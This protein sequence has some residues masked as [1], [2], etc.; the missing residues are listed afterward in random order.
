MELGD[1]KNVEIKINYHKKLNWDHR[2]FYE[3][4]C[5]EILRFG[6]LLQKLF[7]L[8]HP[9]CRW[10]LIMKTW[11][12]CS[13]L[14]RVKSKVPIFSRANSLALS[15]KFYP[16]RNNRKALSEF[17]KSCSSMRLVSA[18]CF[19]SLR[20]FPAND[21]AY[22]RHLHVPLEQSVNQRI[23]CRIHNQER[24]YD[25]ASFIGH[26]MPRKSCA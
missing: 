10:G 23:H 13:S 4:V 15:V 9:C 1:K 8:F 18:G 3:I 26:L 11:N 2:T 6:L 19:A 14:Q 12:T 25:L 21:S 24:R 17:F 5:S 22:H 7:H 16:G 20:G